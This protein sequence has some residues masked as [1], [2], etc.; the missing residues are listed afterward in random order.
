MLDAGQGRDPGSRGQAVRHL[1]PAR[2]SDHKERQDQMTLA[3]TCWL[4]LGAVGIVIMITGALA[5]AYFALRS[6]LRDD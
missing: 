6:L 1:P 5:I 2:A 4:I 3:D